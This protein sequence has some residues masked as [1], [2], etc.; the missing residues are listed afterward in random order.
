MAIRGS[1]SGVSHCSSKTI[2]KLPRSRFCHCFEDGRYPQVLISTPKKTWAPDG[3]G[4]PPFLSLCWQPCWQSWGPL[5]FG[6]FSPLT[7]PSVC[8]PATRINLGTKQQLF[9]IH[10]FG[11]LHCVVVSRRPWIEQI[12][13]ELWHR[14][15]SDLTSHLCYWGSVQV[16]QE[17]LL[18]TQL[19][20]SYAWCQVHIEC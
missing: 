11:L 3:T 12:D 14:F 6:S 4:W 19:N 18:L 9:V 2:L 5:I 20:Q 10:I 16:L 7:F 1:H 15:S 17:L 13:N 8:N